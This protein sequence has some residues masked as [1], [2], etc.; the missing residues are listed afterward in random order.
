[1]NRDNNSTFIP[2]SR[3]AAFRHIR[4]KHFST[5]NASE[6][7]FIYLKPKS[8]LIQGNR[9]TPISL[10]PEIIPMKLENDVNN[11]R[12]VIDSSYPYFDVVR[13]L[14]NPYQ[15]QVFSGRYTR[16]PYTDSV[17]N[18][19][20]VVVSKKSTFYLV[21]PMLLYIKDSSDRT[22]LNPNRI[23]DNIVIIACQDSLGT[24]VLLVNKKLL[25]TV[26]HYFYTKVR[27]LSYVIKEMSEDVVECKYCSPCFEIEQTNNTNDLDDIAS[28]AASNILG[29]CYFNSVINQADCINNL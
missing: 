19:R 7:G 21:G 13:E 14:F 5:M 10:R 15:Y 18:I 26:N 2:S 20:K 12:R 8:K 17:K 27:V 16:S 28:D 25:N 6:L 4:H 24:R 23:K 1:M 29:H 9:I 11:I 3:S 22:T